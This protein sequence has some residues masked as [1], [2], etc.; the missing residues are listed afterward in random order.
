MSR[1][2]AVLG[3]DDN[4]LVA[5]HCMAR[6]GFNVTLVHETR[7]P[8]EDALEPGWISP[9]LVRTLGLEGAGLQVHKPAAWA[10]IPLPGGEMLRLT[11]DVTETARAIGRVSPRDGERWPAFCRRMHALAGFVE[12]LYDAPPPDP[13]TESLGGLQDLVR[14]GVRLRRLGRAAME[15]FLRWLPMSAADLLDEWFASDALKGALGVHAVRHLAQGPRAGGT[16]FNLLHHHVGHPPGVFSSIYTNARA[17]LARMD[18]VTVQAARIEQIVVRQGRVAGVALDTGS[19]IEASAVISTLPPARTLL[20]LLDP[21]LLAPELVRAVRRIRARGV[22]A[23]VAL[24]LE[25]APPFTALVLASSLDHVERAY[26]DYKHGRVSR[27]PVI[28][29]RACGTDR[30]GRHRVQVRAQYVPHAPRDGEWDTA[31]AEQ[32]ARLLTARVAARVPGLAES[33]VTERVLTPSDIAHGNGFPQGQPYHAE[34]A[35]DQVLWMRPVPQLAGYRTPVRGL[36]LGGPAM[37]PGGGIV[38]AAGAH[39]AAVAAADLSRSET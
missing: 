28:E 17:V 30:D 4:A 32:L 15:D 18:G 37:H 11:P 2:V 27:E 35:L 24:T 5:A 20:E 31:R 38:G 25:R 12:T 7:L 10:E 13:L 22:A 23:E 16:A 39:A 3:S 19:E 36:H 14:A 34:L 6:A 29:A 26:D 1:S 8:E 9:R 21:S 33:V